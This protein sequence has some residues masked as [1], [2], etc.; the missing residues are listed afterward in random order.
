M[1]KSLAIAAVLSLGLAGYASAQEATPAPAAPM[2]HEMHHHH[3]HHHIIIT[4]T[5]TTRTTWPRRRRK[6]PS[7]KPAT[8]RTR[9]LTSAISG[10]PGGVLSGEPFLSAQPFGRPTSVV[11]L[12]R[13]DPLARLDLDPRPLGQSDHRPP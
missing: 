6:R 12:F 3:H 5:I 13:S 9:R 2:S 11:G 4:T 7:R 10:S 8:A 1:I